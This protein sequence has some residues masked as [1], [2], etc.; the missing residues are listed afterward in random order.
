MCRVA[1][2]FTQVRVTLLGNTF[3][4]VQVKSSDPTITKVKVKK[5][6]WWNAT[7]WAYKS[8]LCFSVEV[9]GQTKHWGSSAHSL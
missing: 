3:T 9:I 1:K 6:T 4:Q 2:I 5:S 7:V 8:D